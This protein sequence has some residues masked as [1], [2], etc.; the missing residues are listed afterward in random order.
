M[1]T[2]ITLNKISEE[3]GYTTNALHKK[4]HDCVFTEGV[5]YIRSPDGRVHFDVREYEKWL[6]TNYRKA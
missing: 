1:L 3:S 6:K 2:Y 5:H 4:I